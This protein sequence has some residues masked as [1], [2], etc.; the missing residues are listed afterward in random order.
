[1]RTPSQQA[2]KWVGTDPKARRRGRTRTGE[3]SPAGHARRPAGP[4][5]AVHR[6]RGPRFFQCDS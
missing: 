5:L 4:H 2:A 1:M 6:D 3:H